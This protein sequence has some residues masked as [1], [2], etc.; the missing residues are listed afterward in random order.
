MLAKER[1]AMI[2][3]FHKLVVML[4]TQFLELRTGGFLCLARS[5]RVFLDIAWRLSYSFISA[6]TVDSA[7]R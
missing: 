2:A 1:V 7:R 4:E 5:N 3:E 6:V